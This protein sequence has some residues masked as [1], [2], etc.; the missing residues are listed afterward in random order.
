MTDNKK[1]VAELVIILKDDAHSPKHQ[2]L[3]SQK[4]TENEYKELFEKKNRHGQ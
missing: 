1:K 3:A 2:L 4:L